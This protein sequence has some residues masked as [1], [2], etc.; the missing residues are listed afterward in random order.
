MCPS[1]DGRDNARLRDQ[2]TSA[3]YHP[4][5][6]PSS[7]AEAST[8]DAAEHPTPRGDR[9]AVE[10]LP[11]SIRNRLNPHWRTWTLLSEDECRHLRSN[12]RVQFFRRNASGH[13]ERSQRPGTSSDR[14]L[15]LER[16][17]N[18]VSGAAATSS[19]PAARA[20]AEVIQQAVSSPAYAPIEPTRTDRT[21]V[22]EYLDDQGEPLP[23]VRYTV[24]LNGSTYSGRL[25]DDGT[26]TLTNLP[27]GE[28]E[29]VYEADDSQLP[30]LRQQLSDAI[31]GFIEERNEDKA[32]L[33][34]LFAE[35]N[36]VERGL[37]LTGA[38]MVSIFEGGRDTA[39]ALWE[40]ATGSARMAGRFYER[41]QQG[42]NLDDLRDDFATL[43]EA[44][45]HLTSQAEQ[46]FT[47]LHWLATDAET[48]S[49]L[50]NLPQHY[51]ASMSTVQ[52][53]EVLGRVAFDILFA[54]AL[55]V[56]T[57][58][59]AG[60]A[61]VV[62]GSV[63]AIR[64]SAFFTRMVGSLRRIYHL[65][66]GQSIAQRHER[67]S[68]ESRREHHQ[69]SNQIETESLP[70]TSQTTQTQRQNSDGQPSCAAAN[71]PTCGDPINMSNGEE[72]FTA[73]DF[74]VPGPLPLSWQR[75]YRSS[76]SATRHELGHGWHH[77]LCHWL[78]VTAD[79]VIHWD[80]EGN[81]TPYPLPKNGHSLITLDGD[82][83]SRFDDYF[84]VRRGERLYQ[85]EPDPHHPERA[86][87]SQ[88]SSL[89]DHH[90]WQLCYDDRTDLGSNS[91]SSTSRLTG[92]L[93]S[94][95]AE[96]RFEPGRHGWQ[97]IYLRPRPEQPEQRLARYRLNRHGDLIATEGQSGEREQFR[98]QQHLFRWRQLATGLRFL[99]EWDQLT[100]RGRCIRQ[101]AL[102]TQHPDNDATAHYDTRFEWHPE[103]RRSAVIDSRGHRTEY[104]FNDQGQLI[105]QINPDGGTQRWHYN[106]LHQLLH[107][108][109]ADGAETRYR[110][111]DQGRI[112]EQTNAL[113][114]RLRLRYDPHSA[115]PIELRNASD[116]RTRFEYDQ[117]GRLI[118]QQHPDGR[119]EQWHY[120]HDQLA[121]HD[122]AQ[123]QQHHYR[124][125]PVHGTL[126]H[127][128]LLGPLDDQGE[129]PLLDERHFDYD[130]QGRLH[131]ETDRHGR[132]QHFHYDHAGRLLTQV[133]PNGL[134]QRFDYDRAGR[135]IA[136]IDGQ[137]RQRQWHYGSFAQ[138]SR[139]TLPNGQTLRFEYD[140]ERNLTALINGNGQAHRFDYDGN[141]RLISETGPDGRQQ[142][143]HYSPAGHLTAKDDGLIHSRFERNAL[144]QLIREQHQHAER[145]DANTWAEYGYDDQGR[146][147]SARNAHA[148]QGFGY[149][150]QGRLIEDQQ[151]Q[152][153]AGMLGRP[154]PYQHRQHYHYNGQ[155]QLAHIRHHAVRKQPPGQR[156]AALHN[157]HWAPGWTQSCQW[158]PQ[159][160]L[161]RL[162]LNVVGN[163]Y[164]EHHF[165]V[166]SQHYDD[167]GLLSER[168]QGQ[169]LSQ[170][171]YD[172]QQ[173][174]QHYR[175]ALLGQ[176]S[177]HPSASASA[178][179]GHP[180]EQ[181]RY[182]YDDQGRTARIQDHRRGEHHYQYDALGQLTQVQ[183][184]RPGDPSAVT[185]Q[186][187]TDPAG[188]RLPEGLERLLDN[189]LPFHGDRH[190]D[191]DPHGNLIRIRHGKGQKLEQRLSYN[192]QHQLMRIEHY[193]NG[194]RTQRLDF[195][196]DAF[197]RRIDKT[198]Y[199]LKEA[200][201]QAEDQR[202]HIEAYIWQGDTLIQVRQLDRL[203]FLKSHRIYLYDP[204]SHTP[205][206]LWD[207]AL[208]LH[209]LDTDHAGT[210]K[211]MYRHEDGE[212]VWSTDHEVY[213]KT[214][215]NNAKLTHPVTGQPFEPQLRFQGQYE[216]LETGLYQNRYRYYDPG[217]GRY[218]SQD[219]I[220]LSGGLNAYQYCPNPVEFV[221][222]LGLSSKECTDETGRPLSSP[223][224]S[225]LQRVQLQQGV[226][227]PGKNDY[228]HFQESNKQLYRV[229][230]NDSAL[231]NMLEELYP[232]L[233]AFVS[234][235]ARGK[236]SGR[237]PSKLGLTWHHSAQEKGTMEL[238]PIGQHQAPGPVQNTL[239]PNKQGGMEIWGGGVR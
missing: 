231:A 88:I 233:M 162:G 58:L 2:N 197:G 3:S 180:L 215:D 34:A 59:T 40:A 36:A 41:L 9:A 206:A 112:V 178:S 144:G 173:R 32:R 214:R 35:Y 219:P 238:I 117:G 55:A 30:L 94:W 86:R 39:S 195:R 130:D 69:T 228:H 106:S 87:L 182:H 37:I 18:S 73:I 98:Y 196:Y 118:R 236:H 76:A 135:L 61:A 232:G 75:L 239:H 139:L 161:H 234:P 44:A 125:H 165:D 120:Q 209:H 122:D 84:S 81:Q 114:Q 128:S 176:S 1:L 188:N 142:R 119:S 4:P 171:H 199:N 183:L 42:Y 202:S 103:A 38:V 53:A 10:R 96:L 191:Y 153:F 100:P 115:Q 116:W 168:Q 51:F 22:L 52:K 164:R 213:G 154:Q 138:P 8:D 17:G 160:G 201:G 77:P 29:I 101:Y 211:A 200:T 141:E 187:H 198:H 82:R 13:W 27:E 54:I 68:I 74:E 126:S 217:V 43:A 192:A 45:G 31:N 62:A 156:W 143:Y 133:D 208:G 46:A 223:H 169:H 108:T 47:V 56:A 230:S 16:V 137:G 163:D 107:C 225:V 97:A 218:I 193:N 140:S 235:G 57:A 20:T 78:E 28:A 222:P 221:D 67:V 129:R 109:D 146:L 147:T 63:A 6:P 194:Q 212:Q 124:W 90:R 21:L 170:W 85:F 60:A 71:S 83:L 92:A 11:R 5:E 158:H 113:G 148:E 95:G 66:P 159:G 207:D 50:V 19:A 174:L 224:Y 25:E 48:W 72:L 227:Y 210:P 204:G 220:G 105:E 93:T 229:M 121:R 145:P 175:R 134:H 14:W 184:K 166:L 136:H 102:D 132:Q 26:T 49:L 7:S 24:R 179:T 80:D 111:D 189:R 172:P 203:S 127:Y 70:A 131:T 91:A 104:H 151:T 185:Q 123:G 155:G 237:T 23:D 12:E 33:D 110:Y 152:W 150:A 177:N 205:L 149:D 181:R 89:N 79:Q 167:Q 15:C 64:H 216:D 157:D 226:N 190:F 99:F 65:L 186:E